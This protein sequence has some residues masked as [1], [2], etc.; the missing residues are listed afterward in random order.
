[1]LIVASPKFRKAKN[2]DRQN[3]VPSKESLII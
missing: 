1:M 3:F 2:T